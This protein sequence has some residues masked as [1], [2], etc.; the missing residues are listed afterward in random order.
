MVG[1]FDEIHIADTDGDM[2]HVRLLGPDKRGD[3]LIEIKLTG[4]GKAASSAAITLMQLRE[5]LFA[6]SLKEEE[7]N[8]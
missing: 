8:G 6:L 7:S 5:A 3:T 4:K 2:V 1:V